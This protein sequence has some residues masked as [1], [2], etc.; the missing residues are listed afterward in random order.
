ME[1]SYGDG[2][3]APSAWLLA[4]GGHPEVGNL[5]RRPK[6]PLLRQRAP[7]EDCIR[8]LGVD[9]PSR[10]LA[11]ERDTTDGL[12]TDKNSRARAYADDDVTVHFSDEL[13]FCVCVCV[14]LGWQVNGGGAGGAGMGG[15]KAEHGC[16]CALP[17]CR[18]R[19]G[20][21]RTIPWA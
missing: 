7:G 8:L 18:K 10:A 19:Q 1:Q 5:A 21:C 17:R 6:E 12:T 16:H 13:C 2:P 9:L 15:K 11:E 14:W 20:W 3:C 4:L